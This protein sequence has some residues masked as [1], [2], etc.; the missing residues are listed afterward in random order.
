M[1]NRSSDV[2]FRN[3][4]QN[5]PSHHAL[6]AA[7]RRD[8]ERDARMH[9]YSIDSNGY[10]TAPSGGPSLSNGAFQKQN[11]DYRARTQKS[12]TSCLSDVSD[13][14]Q[15]NSVKARIA[16]LGSSADKESQVTRHTPAEQSARMTLAIPNFIDG[17]DPMITNLSQAH[18]SGVSTVENMSNKFGMMTT[19]ATQNPGTCL[20]SETQPPLLTSIVHNNGMKTDKSGL[21]VSTNTPKSMLDRY[22][23]VLDTPGSMHNLPT[24]LQSETAVYA[25]TKPTPVDDDGSV[26]AQSSARHTV[27]STNIFEDELLA[28]E[29]AGD[30]GRPEGV[31]NAAS[32]FLGRTNSN[33]SFRRSKPIS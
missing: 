29:L 30:Y 27:N 13:S 21:S 25:A 1:M 10:R 32:I 19:D 5:R 7:V 16:V 20:A 12:A 22:L 9:G 15:T 8:L 4:T 18:T 31:S 33:I 2:R 24:D 23:A 6:M 28:L 17:E 11:T 3:W 14:T 26:M